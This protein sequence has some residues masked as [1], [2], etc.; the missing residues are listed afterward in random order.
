MFGNDAAFGWSAFTGLFGEQLFVRLSE[1]DQEQRLR[2]KWTYG[3]AHIGGQPMGGYIVVPA[4]RRGD[5]EGE[6]VGP[7]AW[8][9]GLP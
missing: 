3:F 2:E 8:T 7:L 5:T 1:Q 4:A 9:S 6:R